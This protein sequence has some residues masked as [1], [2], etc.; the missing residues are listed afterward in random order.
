MNASIE[1]CVSQL[2]LSVPTDCKTRLYH[3]E[4]KYSLEAILTRNSY[5]S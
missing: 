4:I 2:N 1:V 5:K 3:I